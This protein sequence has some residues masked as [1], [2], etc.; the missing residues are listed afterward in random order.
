MQTE[1][2]IPGWASGMPC[3]IAQLLLLAHSYAFLTRR[4]TGVP[5]TCSHAAVSQ[6]AWSSCGT[7][8]AAA[9]GHFA[10][11]SGEIQIWNPQQRCILLVLKATNTMVR[12]LAWCPNRLILA[13]G[14]ANG[15][16][17]VWEVVNQRP[18]S[19]GRDVTVAVPGGTIS[20]STSTGINAKVKANASTSTSTGTSGDGPSWDLTPFEAHASCVS[21]VCVSM[22]GNFIASASFDKTARIWDVTTGSCLHVLRGHNS[23]I[24]ACAF[25]ASESCTLHLATG[26]EDKRGT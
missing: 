5:Q 20:T 24:Y 12:S 15:S 8:L 10:S 3:V 23:R 2:E 19:A 1:R 26:S 25:D 21:S 11:T 4:P 6:L 18:A 17:H 16:V 9:V 13:S 7:V 14:H 22:C